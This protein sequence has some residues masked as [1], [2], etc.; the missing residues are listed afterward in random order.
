MRA[1]R[2]AACAGY[3]GAIYD[4]KIAA[5]YR[6]NFYYPLGAPAR[7]GTR[8]RRM[9]NSR[10]ERRR[11]ARRPRSGISRMRADIPTRGSLN[12]IC[13]SGRIVD[14]LSSVSIYGGNRPLGIHVGP[15]K[16]G[17]REVGMKRAGVCSARERETA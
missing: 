14:Q 7:P 10:S 8:R 2:R 9:P 17:G 16:R 1:A 4:T 15:E 3:N 6:G 11:V 12:A 13:G 5:R